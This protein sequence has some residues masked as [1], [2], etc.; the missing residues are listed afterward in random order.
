MMKK[1]IF[2]LLI[3]FNM[4]IFAQYNLPGKLDTMFYVTIH[5]FE[6]KYAVSEIHT[7]LLPR[8]VQCVIDMSNDSLSVTGAYEIKNLYFEF[9]KVRDIFADSTNE[10]ISYIYDKNIAILFNYDKNS[11]NVKK[12]H[13]SGESFIRISID[14]IIAYFIEDNS[15]KET[16]ILI[17]HL[18]SLQSVCFDSPILISEN[19]FVLSKWENNIE[20]CK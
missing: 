9:G 7:Y 20:F 2:F 17:P 5:Y 8:N 18:L 6:S 19:K 15:K 1:N 10:F 16:H 13:S 4:K 3:V 11:N 14:E 12:I